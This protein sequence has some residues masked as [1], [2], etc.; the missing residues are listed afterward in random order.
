[1]INWINNKYGTNIDS[2]DLDEIKSFTLLWNIFEGTIFQNNFSINRLDTEIQNRNLD[3][4]RFQDVFNFF[5]RRYVVQ[6]QFTDRFQYLN[7]RANDRLNLVQ[8]VLLGVNQNDNDKLLVIGIIIYRFRNNLFHGLKDFRYLTEQVENFQ[9]ANRYL[10][11]LL[12]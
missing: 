2:A 11:I 1:M 6:G 12:E 7:L 4:Q 3:F 8:Q 10:Q 9:N 5:Q